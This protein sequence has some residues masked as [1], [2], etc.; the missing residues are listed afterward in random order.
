MLTQTEV[1]IGRTLF[2]GSML[3]IF[4][5]ALIECFNQFRKESTSKVS[6]SFA[7]AG[8]LFMVSFMIYVAYLGIM[9][10]KTGRVL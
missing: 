9:I 3:S 2:F 6:F 8:G 5:F 7:I 1:M 4:I 10:E